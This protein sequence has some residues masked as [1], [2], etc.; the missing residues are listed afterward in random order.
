MNI[1]LIVTKSRKL[2]AA[3]STSWTDA[4]LLIDINIAYEN[5]VTEILKNDRT[6][7]FDDQNFSTSPILTTT[8]VVDQ[9][10]YAFSTVFLNILAVDVLDSSGI[11]QR[12]TS[13]D[14]SQVNI[15]L[16]ELYP[17]SALPFKYDVRYGSIWLYPAPAANDVT[18]AAGLRI[19]AQRNADNFTSAQ[20]TTG[21]KV[22]GF[23]IHHEVLAFL[24]AKDYAN[25][26]RKDRVAYLTNEADKKLEQIL[27][28]YAGREKGK[29]R[30]IKFSQTGHI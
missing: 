1:N 5:I 15:P 26:Y 13:I 4:N 7:E 20:V 11:Y 18:T 24:A 25:S 23:S 19:Y 30:V 28:F 14:M 2:V 6:W 3:D 21:T 12:L 29:R 17:D 8:L 22:P 9:N 27:E 16:D 10:D